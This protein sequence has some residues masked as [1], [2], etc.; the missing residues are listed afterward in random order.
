MIRRLLIA[1]ASFAVLTLPASAAPT[2]QRVRGTIESATPGVL[3]LKTDDGTSIVLQL[4]SD[5]K[6]ASVTASSLDAVKEGV[7]I[8]TATKGEPATALEVAVFPESMRGTGEGHYD[9]DSITDT[10]R[11]GATPVKSSMT[12]GTIAATA[13]PM[14]KSS[15]TNGTVKGGSAAGGGKK[16]TVTYEGGRSLDVTVPPT[17]PVVTFAPADAAILKAGAKMFAIAAGDGAKLDAKLVAV[18]KDGVTPPM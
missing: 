8:G 7:F 12:N 9:W 2:V 4:A 15:M 1:S 17:A 16:I 6:F 18:G 10:T 11:S 14:T 3:T 13:K 5:T